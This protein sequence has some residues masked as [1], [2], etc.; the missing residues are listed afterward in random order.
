MKKKSPN[1]AV[2]SYYRRQIEGLEIELAAARATI[3]SQ[4]S[5]LGVSPHFC[6]ECNAARIDELRLVIKQL[7]TEK[8]NWISQLTAARNVA[9]T[10]YDALQRAEAELYTATDF[11]RRVQEYFKS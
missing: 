10:H 5:Q 4:K 2:P 7:E 3:A 9:N 11:R 1:K 6:N 8:E